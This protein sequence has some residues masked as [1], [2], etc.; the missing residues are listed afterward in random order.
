ME[1]THPMRA[2]Y[3]IGGVRRGRYIHFL[4]VNGETPPPAVMPEFFSNDPWPTDGEV[5]DEELC[6]NLN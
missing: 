2:V 6:F 5:V 3:M 1:G 4:L